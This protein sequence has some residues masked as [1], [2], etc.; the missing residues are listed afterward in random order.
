MIFDQ[1]FQELAHL[2]ELMLNSPAPNTRKICDLDMWKVGNHPGS[3]FLTCRV[4]L[5]FF[6]FRCIVVKGLL[7]AEEFEF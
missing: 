1:R 2:A 7:M 3:V 4:C 6:F 5:V